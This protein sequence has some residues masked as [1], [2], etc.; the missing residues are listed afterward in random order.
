MQGLLNKSISPTQCH[1]GKNVGSTENILEKW[2]GFKFPEKGTLFI[3]AW[4]EQLLL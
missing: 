2:S 1:Q 4:G 3:V